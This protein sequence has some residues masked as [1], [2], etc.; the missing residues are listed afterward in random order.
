MTLNESENVLE[1]EARYWTL[2]IK[3]MYVCKTWKL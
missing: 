2:L 1:V 3:Y